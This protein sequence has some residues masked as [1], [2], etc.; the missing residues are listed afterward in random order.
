MA[1]LRL[2]VIAL[3]LA[4]FLALAIWKGWLGGGA[5]HGEPERLSNQLNSDKIRLVD[6]TPAPRPAPWVAEAPTPE[7]P[8]APV[9]AAPPACVAFSGLSAEQSAELSARIARAGSGF[10]LAESR[11][12]APSSWWVH[13]PSQG[14]KESAERK[15]AELR[16]LGV[17]DLFIVQDAGPSQYAISLGLFRNEAAA[18]RQLGMLRDRGVRSAQVAT[19]GGALRIEVRGPSDRL[20]SLASDLSEPLQGVSRLECAP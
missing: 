10:R 5:S 8:P 4:N 2:V 11:G 9:E 13:I 17:M 14:T 1:S 15:A 18:A 3:L 19:R 16:R 6:A 20:A 12:G 7:I